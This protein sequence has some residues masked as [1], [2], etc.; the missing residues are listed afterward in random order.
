MLHSSLN[1][2]QHIEVINYTL[3][4]FAPSLLLTNESMT[5]YFQSNNQRSQMSEYIFQSCC[6]N[7]SATFLRGMK[8]CAEHKIINILVPYFYNTTNIEV[9]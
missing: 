1:L 2:L 9:M 8:R 5:Y 6:G 3:D 4:L 7:D